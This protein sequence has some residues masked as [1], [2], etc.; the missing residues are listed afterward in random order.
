MAVQ[1]RLNF[2]RT[3]F[4]DKTSLVLMPNSQF[5]VFLVLVIATAPM[6]AH[7]TV[8][9]QPD[10]AR[11]LQLE[12]PWLSG[13]AV[14]FALPNQGAT[15][16][17]SSLVAQLFDRA[18]LETLRQETVGLG[19][20][21]TVFR[22][23]EGSYFIAVTDPVNVRQV[24]VK[25]LTTL[26]H[27]LPA[28]SVETALASL[29]SDLLF[30]EGSPKADFEAVFAARV[31]A[32]V[33]A[34][35]YEVAG[36]LAELDAAAATV[37]HLTVPIRQVPATIAEMSGRG[38]GSALA[39]SV[40]SFPVMSANGRP[41]SLM[42]A[43]GVIHVEPREI[44][45]SWVGSLYGLPQGTTLL[46]A[47]LFRLLV[48]Q[49]LERYRDSSLFELEVDIDA[50]GHLSIRFSA[51]PEGG[52]RWESRLEQAFRELG[53]EATR[54]LTADIFRQVRGRWSRE[55]STPGAIAQAAT[56]ALLRGATT[57]QATFFALSPEKL[58]SV[59]RMAEVAGGS[60]LMVRLVYGA[61]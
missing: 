34:G 16:R 12:V 48:E 53:S 29:R 42:R 20:K 28:R 27:P 17:Q 33:E 2:G 24:H 49:Y 37:T 50:W 56:E 9:P 4:Y 57:E 39:L 59:E 58:P 3:D 5:F 14:A 43:D 40:A 41:G 21:V 55:G 51:T 18:L 45:N 19:V 38:A 54:R 31:Y 36:G 52:S 10:I 30:R 46:E 22:R 61:F 26:R 25:I 32:G 13:A 11:P 15:D 8:Q 6:N 1:E 60:S 47:H 23:N 35:E 7:A 44:V